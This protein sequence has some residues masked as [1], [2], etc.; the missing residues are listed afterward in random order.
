MTTKQTAGLLAVALALAL[1]AY[2]LGVVPK[3]TPNHVVVNIKPLQ[4][5]SC[6]VIQLRPSLHS[7]DDI[8]WSLDSAASED[9]TIR[10]NPGPSPGGQPSIVVRPG[11][12]TPPSSIYVPLRC[13]FGC[14]IPY[15]IDKCP[16]MQGIGVHISH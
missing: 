15:T 10:F 7:G 14:D 12:T 16:S 8:A 2:L 11:T 1:L 5:G 9:Y 6:S 13:Y 3:G 4:G